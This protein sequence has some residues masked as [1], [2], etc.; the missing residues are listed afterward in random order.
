MTGRAAVVVFAL[1][2]TPAPLHAQ[3]SVFTVSVPSA[4]VHKGPSIGTPVIG[5]VNDGTVMTVRRNLGSWVK[6]D[7]PAGPDGF[8]YLHVTTGR[9][10]SRG[11]D[12]PTSTPTP[13][14][15]AVSRAST[16][17]SPAPPASDASSATPV[18]RQAHRPSR[19]REEV[20]VAT[21]QHATAISHVLGIGGLFGSTS[22]FG[23]TSR[24]WRADRLGVQIAFSRESMTSA[25]APGRV[26]SIQLE[27][28]VVYG[29]FDH[30][31]DY[32]WVRPYV[33]GG[34]AIRHQNLEHATPAS[35]DAASTGAGVRIFG[36]GEWTF[37][38]APRFALSVDAGYRRFTTSF[39]G[40]EPPRFSAFVSGHWYVK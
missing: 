11:P 27:P 9:L 14:S 21:P 38:G 18:R 32:F 34:V 5:H 28:A 23:A 7:W 15:A 19:P 12:I 39:A 40:F 1:A 4:D 25:A 26:A 10:G 33:G 17:S 16:S 8:G 2:L 30:V 31:S 20:I 13:P 3:D 22:S 37:A 24:A 36:G 35:G 6:I 29:L